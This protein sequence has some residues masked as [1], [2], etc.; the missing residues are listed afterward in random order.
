MINFWNQVI[1]KVHLNIIFFTFENDALT[2]D[3]NP[4]RVLFVKARLFS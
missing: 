2:N 1:D 3:E 4:M